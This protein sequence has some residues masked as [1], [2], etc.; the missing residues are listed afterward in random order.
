[1]LAVMRWWKL[2]FSSTWLVLTAALVCGSQTGCKK[3]RSSGDLKVAGASD[4]VFAMAEIVPEFERATGTRV[5]FIP[6]SSGKLAAQIRNGAP[7]DVFFS[8]NQSFVEDV[9][10][11]EACDGATQRI[12]ARGRIVLWAGPDGEPAL[13]SDLRGL[14]D[15]RY[16]RI[17]IANPEHA[18][19]GAAAKQALQK[20]GIYEQLK[21][22]LVYGSNIKDTMQ[23]A[24]TGNA[25]VAVIALSLAK[26]SPGANLPV[27]AELHEPIDQAMVVCKHG[28]ATDAGRD[29]ATFMASPEVVA[30]MESYGFEVP[31]T[32]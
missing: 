3:S 2:S 19:Y 11:A 29:F 12:Y 7:Y 4:L 6:G 20:A 1:M 14:T 9:V 24:E 32:P 8:A 18:P 10:A 27:P 17:A 21:D 23:L 25:E 26:K 30:L 16:Q 15:A 5:T 28:S 31:A 13:P 22:R